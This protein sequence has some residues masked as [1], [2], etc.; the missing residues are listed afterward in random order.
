MQSL[1]YKRALIHCKIGGFA[2][3]FYII[4]PWIIN[5]VCTVS[6]I[7]YCRIILYVR[8]LNCNMFVERGLNG[9]CYNYVLE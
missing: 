6:I 4:I 7:I 3:R 2:C 5:K 9:E 1:C 8:I